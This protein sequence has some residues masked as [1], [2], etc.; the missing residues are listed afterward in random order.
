MPDTEQGCEKQIRE[1]EQH[2]DFLIRRLYGTK[3]E[4]ASVFE[5]EGQMFLFNE[6][7][8]CAGLNA[9]EPDLVEAGKH[10]C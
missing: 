7:E 9:R 3:L 1:L 10:L 8:S 5:I 2:V 4:K 6:L